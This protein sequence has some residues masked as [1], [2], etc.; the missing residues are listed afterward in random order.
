MHVGLVTPEFQIAQFIRPFIVRNTFDRIHRRHDP[1]ATTFYGS[2]D[3]PFRFIETPS[4]DPNRDVGAAGS[5]FRGIGHRDRVPEGVPELTATVI[6]VRTR[7]NVE[8]KSPVG[9][10]LK[11]EFV[12]IR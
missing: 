4:G 1:L 7:I 12:K 8:L 10:K 9:P 3:Q 11:K 6:D 2:L 5:W